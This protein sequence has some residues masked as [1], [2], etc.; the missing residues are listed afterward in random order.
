MGAV[1]R[2]E[3][4]DAEGVPVGEKGR[5]KTSLGTPK[6]KKL[7]IRFDQVAKREGTDR[8][9]NQ[10]AVEGGGNWGKG[11]REKKGKFVP[12]HPWGRIFWTGEGEKKEPGDEAHWNAKK[13]K[14]ANFRR[15]RGPAGQGACLLMGSLAKT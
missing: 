5:R 13:N 7:L 4:P 3:E 14:G 6:T 15:G 11:Q 1:A 10:E 8:T 2:I 9:F 12:P